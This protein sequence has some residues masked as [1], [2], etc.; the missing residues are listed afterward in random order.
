MTRGRCSGRS[1]AAVMAALVI[2]RT[3][4]LERL[5]ED[6][7]PVE[8]ELT[9]AD[10]IKHPQYPRSMSNQ[11]GMHRHPRNVSHPPEVARFPLGRHDG[12]EAPPQTFY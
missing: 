10:E 7:Q 9:R 3:A 5:S 4:E 11:P 1:A 6:H 12:V 2:D 8:P